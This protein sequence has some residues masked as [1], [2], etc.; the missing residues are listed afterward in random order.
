MDD[1]VKKLRNQL[2]KNNGIRNI[3]QT[4][5]PLG[6]MEQ[7]NTNQTYGEGYLNKL[8]KP[9]FDSYL[10]DK[11]Q[12][13]LTE[14]TLKK[15]LNTTTKNENFGDNAFSIYIYLSISH[16]YFNGNKND[17]FVSKLF[18]NKETAPTIPMIRLLWD[19][20]IKW[21]EIEDDNIH[22]NLKNLKQ[23][24]GKKKFDSNQLEMFLHILDPNYLFNFIA[25]L[26]LYF[27]EIVK[28]DVKLCCKIY[29]FL[30]ASP[31]FSK[32]KRLMALFKEAEKQKVKLCN[33][34]IQVPKE[35]QENK[36]GVSREAPMPSGPPVEQG[37]PGEP[38]PVGEEKEDDQDESEGKQSGGAVTFANNKGLPLERGKNSGYTPEDH[39]LIKPEVSQNKY[40]D[41]APYDLDSALTLIYFTGDVLFQI[42]TVAP[43]VFEAINKHIME[44]EGV[45]ETRV[46]IEDINRTMEKLG[47]IQFQKIESSVKR[48]IQQSNV[49][50]WSTNMP[51]FFSILNIYNST[52]HYLRKIIQ[53][54]DATVP[55]TYA[56]FPKFN[57]LGHTDPGHIGSSV[58]NLLDQI[59]TIKKVGT[60]D[61]RVKETI[62]L[63]NKMNNIVTG[64]TVCRKLVDQS[65]ST[66]KSM[67]DFIL[68]ED[69]KIKNRYNII[70]Y[71]E[72]LNVYIPLYSEFN[73]KLSKITQAGNRS[74]VMMGFFDRDYT[75]GKNLENIEFGI[76]NGNN[77]KINSTIIKDIAGNKFGTIDP[78]IIPELNDIISESEK[79]KV[80]LSIENYANNVDIEFT[81]SAKDEDD[82][83]NTTFKARLIVNDQVLTDFDVELTHDVAKNPQLGKYQEGLVR[84]NI[85]AMIVSRCSL[86][87][88]SIMMAQSIKVGIGEVTSSGEI[89]TKDISD[90]PVLN[91]YSHNIHSLEGNLAL[92]LL[93][94]YESFT[95]VDVVS[96][97]SKS[98]KNIFKR[99][100]TSPQRSMYMLSVPE[101]EKLRKCPESLFKTYNDM[102]KRFN[103]L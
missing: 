31:S 28:A 70:G 23:I 37:V 93:P 11:H 89:N 91:L 50:K 1:L 12:T 68:V 13:K 25:W 48:F 96:S 42:H 100:F 16:Q 83:K 97:I 53:D 3:Q 61:L 51:L 15:I 62:N 60:S 5:K 38:L 41:I 75:V 101:I 92:L 67:R 47:G 36:P 98:L 44:I 33:P 34:V 19:I 45:Q 27:I 20:F 86:P 65:N 76:Y 30:L 43:D 94:I 35:S 87:I 57:I 79:G 21:C 29:D 54:D 78:K 14:E 58:S 18:G 85:P 66:I 6:C 82:E 46:D 22:Q 71:N 55:E 24:L 73:G 81:V 2:N 99:A 59:D 32:N 49:N 103:I 90:V 17:N 4:F 102:I 7:F 52:N 84:K 63:M 26:K 80:Q 69:N 64:I 77:L 10:K 9:M 56:I 40:I 88:C 95:K 72:D 74:S 39:S 8:I